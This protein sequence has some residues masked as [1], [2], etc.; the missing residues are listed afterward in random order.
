MTQIYRWPTVYTS[1]HVDFRAETDFI[2]IYICMLGEKKINKSE[3]ES[4]EML[5]AKYV[6]SN[7]I[8]RE[9]MCSTAKCKS[10]ARCMNAKYKNFMKAIL[11]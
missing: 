11:S 1:L 5:C 10:P 8:A 4:Q 2:C 9:H 7:Y 3:S 6:F